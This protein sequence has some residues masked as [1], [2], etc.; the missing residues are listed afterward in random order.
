[1]LLLYILDVA[2]H[3]SD[4]KCSTPFV[5]HTETNINSSRYLN[6]PANAALF[7]QPPI[8]VKRR[9][10]LTRNSETSVQLNLIKCY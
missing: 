8:T 6:K 4:L 9:E 3:V 1:V 2:G 7:L 5:V 10:K